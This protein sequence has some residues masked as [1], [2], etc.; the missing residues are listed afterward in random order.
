MSIEP[1]HSFDPT[2]RAEK[3]LV[4][5]H[6]LRRHNI[7]DTARHQIPQSGIFDNY[8]EMRVVYDLA[9]R[10]FDL[11]NVT[12]PKDVLL[13]YFD[14]EASGVLPE[15]RLNIK[16]E[17]ERWYAKTDDWADDF[18]K[19]YIT[20]YVRAAATERLRDD[21]IQHADDDSEIIKAIDSAKGV[22]ERDLFISSPILNPFADI[23]RNMDIAQRMPCGLPFI[24]NMVDGGFAIGEIFGILAPSGGGKTTL[25]LQAADGLV[26]DNKHVLYIGTEQRLR[27]DLSIRMFTLAA[28]C[29]R[30]EFKNG[31]GRV[32][33]EVK[34][35]LKDVTPRWTEY[36]HFV[37]MANKEIPSINQVFDPLRTL[38]ESGQHP[39][40]VILDWWGRL[41]D[42]L[43]LG[44]LN[45][46]S[47]PTLLRAHA[48]NWL[49]DVKQVAEDYNTRICVL[50]QLSGEQAAKGSKA[51]PNAN[52]AQEDRNFNNMFDFCFAVGKMNS[53]NEAV[54]IAD[55]ARSSARTETYIQLDGEYCRFRP[56]RNADTTAA[57]MMT[58]EAEEAAQEAAIQDTSG[59]LID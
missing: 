35:M 47:D 22:I 1:Y 40:L 20:E 15:L 17:I 26:C 29:S 36:F 46:T 14:E 7:M 57:A 43:T 53:D 31:Y 5:S 10:H 28:R 27:G 4:L 56:S 37:D 33:P 58:P 13:V 9:Q 55:K 18:V 19:T 16:Q 32:S 44:M 50:H 24:D 42:K 52:Q 49:H 8:E 12:I 54:F 2:D 3:L 45:L 11:H 41:K 48:R 6:L 39:S 21:L 23:E 30:K 38:I 34:K 25:G 51:K 59:Y